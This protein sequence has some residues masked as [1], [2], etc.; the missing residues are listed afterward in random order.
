MGLFEEIRP[1]A[2]VRGLDAAG[3]ADIVQVTRFSPDAVNL[4]F[5]ING[6]VAERL[7][8]RGE[9]SL[10]EVVESGRAYGFGADGALL[11]LASEAYRIRLA[12][13]F[14]PYLAI[15]SSLVEALPHQITA[16]YGEM[17]PR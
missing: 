1:G 4:V 7:L 13:L 6:R 11:K 5:R 12:H 3:L 10:L 2:R 15:S 16:V 14:D 17:L 8:Y 9:E